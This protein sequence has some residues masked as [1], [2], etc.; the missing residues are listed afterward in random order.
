[1]T[2]GF[3]MLALTASAATA[4]A[5]GPAKI[6]KC[7]TLSEPGSYE[8]TKNLVATGNCLV[9][10]A[11]FVTIDLKGFVMSGDG[12]GTGIGDAD[13]GRKGIAVRNGT[14][15]DF[16][17]GI[18]LSRS[19]NCE[20]EK[21]RAIDNRGSGIEVFANSIVTGN[22]ASGNG[23][24]IAA[25]ENSTVTGN[26]ASENGLGF[27]VPR[28]LISGN[29]ASDNTGAGIIVDCPSNLVGNMALDNG[30]D[31]LPI[32]ALVDCRFANNNP[33]P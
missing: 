17:E 5:A 10:A 33:A 29:I 23:K 13:V 27:S 19:K 2:L 21:I 15:T 14:I 12:T 20:I 11:D 4:N 3:A 26:N 22:T 24:G 31:I 30:A 32:G 25:G 28:S 16:G 9:V 7:T 1:M 18:D 6:Q 8:L